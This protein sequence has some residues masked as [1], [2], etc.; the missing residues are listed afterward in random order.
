MVAAGL[1]DVAAIDCSVL[2]QLRRT[3]P[4][5]ASK[6][7]VLCR[8]GPNP[9]QPLIM[10]NDLPEEL[11]CSIRKA[12]LE[13]HHNEEGRSVLRGLGFAGFV[14]VDRKHLETVGLRLGGEQWLEG[15]T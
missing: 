13:M 3:A 12:V 2:R 5:V 11:K 15:G 4:G 8:L 7:R 6:L 1:V 10:C 9:I 14:E